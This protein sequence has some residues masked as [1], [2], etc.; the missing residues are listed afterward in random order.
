MAKRAM[1]T[2]AVM[3]IDPRIVEQATRRAPKTLNVP[4]PDGSEDHNLKVILVE[5]V[6]PVLQELAGLYGPVQRS[7]PDATVMYHANYSNLRV[8][9]VRSAVDIIALLEQMGLISMAEAGLDGKA[10]PQK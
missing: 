3:E 1:V 6:V 8:K 7:Q 4:V 10:M 2:P 5:Q 9:A